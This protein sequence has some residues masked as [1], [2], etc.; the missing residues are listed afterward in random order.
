MATLQGHTGVVYGVALSAD[1]AL[2]ASSGED[3]TVR[4]WAVEGSACLSV[5]Q[6]HR[7]AVRAVAL[8]AD[9]RLLASG[10]LDGTVR[11]WETSSGACVAIL[12]GHGGSVWSV[13]LN[14]DARLLASSGVDGTVRLWDVGSRAYIASLQ[15]H[16]GAVWSA[17]LSGD[18]RVAASGGVDGTVRL[19][20]ADSRV[21]VATLQGHTSVIRG[22]ALSADG[23]QVASSGVDGTIRLWEVRGGACVTTLQE[24]PGTIYG[25]AL[26]ADGSLLAS[27]ELDGTVRLRELQS[28][29]HVATLQ[30]HTGVAYGVALSAD[31]ALLASCGLDGTIQLW[32]PQTEACVATLQGHTGGVNGVALSADGALLASGG[33]DGTVRLWAADIGRCVAV[34]QG[35]AGAVYC[36]ALSGDGRLLASGGLDGT[37]RLWATDSGRSVAILQ[38]DAGVVRGVALSADGRL[39]ASGGQDGIVRLWDPATCTALL[40]LRPDRP[41]E[42]MDITGLSGV[43]EAQKA[44]LLA[45]GAVEYALPGAA[46]PTP[47]EAAQPTLSTSISEAA[48]A[49]PQTNLPPSSTTFVGRTADI[50][51]LAQALDRTAPDGARLLTLIGVA[52]CGKTR[53]ALAVA[54]AML[55]TYPDGTWLVELAPSPASPVADPALVAAATLTALGLREQPGQVPLDALV[56]HLRTRRLLLVLDNC[57]HLVA[58]C[59]ALATRLLVACPELHILATSQL[60]LG[61]PEEV[62]CP[63]A[64]LA[65]PD[66]VEDAPAEAALAI[67]ERSDAVQL[68]VARAQAMRPGFSLS[69]ATAASVAAIC[70]QL[71]GLPLAIELAAARLN[72]LS[73]EDLLTRLDDRFRLLR[74]G[75][76]TADERH[77]ALQATMDWSYGLLG[78]AEQALLRR[79]AV[80]AGGWD[81]AAAEVVCAGRLGGSNPGAAREQGDEVEPSAVLELLDA[82]LD[83]SLVY[84]HRSAGVPRY[85]LLETVRQYGLQRLERAGETAAVRDRHLDWCVTLTERAAPALL[86][87]E[88]V[89]WLGRLGREH[90]NLRAALKWALDHGLKTLGLRVAGGL[91]MFWLRRSHQREGRHW[92]E[93]LLA[94][95]AADDDATSV[96]V[97]ARAL[98]GA[99]WLA[100]DEQDY[101]QASALF[102]RSGALHRALGHDDRTTGL[103]INAAMEARAGGDYGRA[104]ALLEQ[105]LARHRAL[106]N[107]EGIIVGGLGLSLSRLALVLAEQGEYARAAALYEECLALVRELGDREGSGIALLGLGD[108]ARDQGDAARVRA[109]C[110]GT[111]ALFRELGHMWAI[112]FSL[113]NLAQ[114]AY[115]EGDTAQASQLAEESVAIFRDLE[116]VPSVAEVLV[117]EGRVRG[118]RGEAAAARA[119]L[120]EALT[121]AWAKGPRVVVAAALEE[122]GVQAVRRGHAQH[123]LLLLAPA[124]TLRQTMGA[125]LRLADRPG[126]EDALTAARTALSADTF[127]EVWAAGQTLSLEQAVARALA[128][129]QG[130]AGATE[131]ASGM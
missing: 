83:R 38:R 78:P 8:S 13:S 68:F 119:S 106:G 34:L 51:A 86:G 77:Q 31:G 4:I 85:G 100:E 82:L 29:R 115:L 25:V 63:V 14:T 75:G 64:P 17:A 107:R 11:L 90:D 95:D 99:A 57:E 127:D 69:A 19:W 125:P 37:V 129:P 112:G 44:A 58:A 36:V 124:A 28:G 54:D 5:L 126:M 2:L 3:G 87:P 35:H 47:A 10:G 114:A 109:Y 122:L 20:E 42:R 1:G 102:A 18:G 48:P 15:G 88:Q 118:A 24:G 22:V 105:S 91:W 53:L 84:V 39:L 55:D 93:A 73:L 67:L 101:G 21:C 32:Q 46:Q 131:L 49:R 70:R 45:L 56:A 41:Y 81:L 27:A 111:L 52:G 40:H 113:N 94:L 9:G 92:L 43:T 117:T 62:V 130:G 26:S 60:A 66:Q 7:G 123:G 121:L 74:R 6:G 97:L 108:I 128:G 33:V 89:V 104:T 96:A 23:R 71:D 61:I 120:A 98:E 72:V 16:G 80:F 79:L 12:Q 65:V 30:G 116:A 50:A 76:R 59:A 110:E 103:L